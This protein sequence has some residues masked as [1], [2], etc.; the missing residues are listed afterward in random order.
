MHALEFSHV[1]GSEITD[2]LDNDLKQ[3]QINLDKFSDEE[4]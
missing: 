1:S 3:H 4:R 2:C